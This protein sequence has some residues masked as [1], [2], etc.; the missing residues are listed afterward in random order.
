[1]TIRVVGDPAKS[2]TGMKSSR[3]GIGARIRLEAGGRSQTVEVRSG[4]SYLSHNDSRA[5]FGLG[6][7]ARVD[8]VEI[9]WPSGRVETIAGVPVDR[10]L[11]AREGQGITGQTASAR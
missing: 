7:A 1:M 10:F 4:G 11:V 8:R 3:D 9:T 6:D 2:A 5:H